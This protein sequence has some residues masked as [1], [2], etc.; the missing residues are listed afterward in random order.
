MKSFESRAK[1]IDKIFCLNDEERDS[2]LEMIEAFSIFLSL[3]NEYV[4]NETYL[5]SNINKFFDYSDKYKR[6][7]EIVLNI[8][9]KVHFE[10]ESSVSICIDSFWKITEVNLSYLDGLNNIISDY[11]CIEIMKERQTTAS[12]CFNIDKK[13]IENIIKYIEKNVGD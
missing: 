9:S 11:I 2:L 3:N 12:K 8:L 1:K 7:K 10:S 13:E 5:K 6:K 4:Y